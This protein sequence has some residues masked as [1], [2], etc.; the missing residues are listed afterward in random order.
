MQTTEKIVGS[1]GTPIYAFEENLRDRH[2]L[3]EYV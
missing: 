3:A 2:S 1:D